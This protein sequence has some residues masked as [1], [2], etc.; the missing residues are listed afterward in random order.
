VVTCFS[1]SLTCRAPPFPEILDCGC[2]DTTLFV[3]YLVCLFDW[4]WGGDGAGM[5]YGMVRTPRFSSPPPRVRRGCA[6]RAPTRVLASARWGELPPAWLPLRDHARAGPPLGPRAATRQGEE[7]VG[8]PW[9]LRVVS[10][11]KRGGQGWTH[12]RGSAA[13]QESAG[14]GWDVARTALQRT[15][16]R[17]SGRLG[18][19]KSARIR[20][21]P[22]RRP[23]RHTQSGRTQ[24]PSGPS[25]ARPRGRPTGR[26]RLYAI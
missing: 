11:G 15:A 14:C 2:R 23:A 7:G 1:C 17:C 12:A 18:G 22:P 9:Q 25:M 10:A 16:Q 19:A 6:P 5:V 3:G 8:T 24:E 20:S 26:G 21:P 4:V 13:S